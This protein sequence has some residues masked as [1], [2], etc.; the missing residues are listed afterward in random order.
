MRRIVFLTSRWLLVAAVI[1]FG[2]RGV[3]ADTADFD[4]LTLAPES[5]WNGPDP[6]GTDVP[7]DFGTTV[8]VGSFSSGNLEFVNRFNLDWGSWDGFAYSNTTDTTTA[9]FGNQ[10]SAY[11]GSG[12]GSGDDN[13]GVAYGHVEGLNPSDAG[14]LQLLPYIELPAGA[15]IGSAY[16]T[17][18][19]Y[20]AISM[21]DGDAFAKQFGGTSGNDEDWFMLSAYGTDASGTPLLGSVDFYLADYRFVDNGQDYIVDAWTLV[22][23]SPLAAAKRVYFNSTSSDVGEFGMNT[24]AYFAIDSIEFAAVPEPP[25]VVLLLTAGMAYFGCSTRRN[26]KS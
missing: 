9:G 12:Q 4:D 3:A 23:L 5:F 13:Y 6:T 25:T 26:R 17:N 14:Q 15:S 7:G 1:F 20:A 10:H 16:I 22:D 19:T 21:R 11:T 2:V 8:R 24:P 18:T